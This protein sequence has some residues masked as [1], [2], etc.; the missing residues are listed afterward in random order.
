MES[1]TILNVGRL[2]PFDGRRIGEVVLIRGRLRASATA[3]QLLGVLVGDCAVFPFLV[4]ESGGNLIVGE[5]GRTS[6]AGQ[7]RVPVA[8]ARR[9][10]MTALTD[11]LEPA[12]VLIEPAEAIEERVGHRYPRTV[13]ALRGAPSEAA[14][15][16]VNPS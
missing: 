16:H 12:D 15:P 7:G 2:P 9:P 14:W 8:A 6:A 10:V 1:R 4:A 5:V 3:E 13:P 11:H